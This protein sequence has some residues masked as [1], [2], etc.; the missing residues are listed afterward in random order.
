M[1]DRPHTNIDI[2]FLPNHLKSFGCLFM[3]PGSTHLLIYMI[4]MFV[5]Y[6]FVIVVFMC[7]EF[8]GGDV[9]KH[10]FLTNFSLMDAAHLAGLPIGTYDFMRKSDQ[11][12]YIAILCRYDRISNMSYQIFVAIILFLRLLFSIYRYC[13]AGTC[14]IAVFALRKPLGEPN[15]A[16]FYQGG[17]NTAG[18]SLCAAHVPLSIYRTAFE[19]QTARQVQVF[20]NELLVFGRRILR[21]T[22]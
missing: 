12:T 20:T 1:V 9:K 5:S 7:L 11:K 15:N 6:L 21:L 22:E 13:F 4:C 16:R 18:T 10:A 19:M 14:T 3:V 2:E 8:Y 17:L